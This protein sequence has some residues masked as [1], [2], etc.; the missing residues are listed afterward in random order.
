MDFFFDVLAFRFHSDTSYL[1]V[2]RFDLNFF[3]SFVWSL[4]EEFTV[5]RFNILI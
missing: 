2:I 3:S 1:C 4:R 5:I